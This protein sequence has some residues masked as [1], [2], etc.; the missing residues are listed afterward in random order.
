MDLTVILKNFLDERGRLLAFP[1]KRKMKTYAL[2]YLAARFQPGRQ[3]TESEVNDLLDDW[4]A[5]HD[6][7]TLRRELYNN[8]FLDRS[9]DGRQYWLED[10]QP[11]L[12]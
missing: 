12:T 8:H 4:T 1:A 10:P 3:Y 7:A 2:H 9:Q 11:E 5:F 6:P